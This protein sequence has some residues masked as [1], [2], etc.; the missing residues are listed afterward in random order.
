MQS[1]RGRKGL[2][3]TGLCLVLLC[4]LPSGCVALSV[5]IPTPESSSVPQGAHAGSAAAVEPASQHR[6]LTASYLPVQNATAISQPD[7]APFAGNDEL[8]VDLLVEQVLARNPTLA[9]MVA[10]WQAASARYPQVTLLEDPMVAGTIGPGTLSPDDPGV[11]FAYRVEVSQKL[12]F[13]GK[14]R[15][16]GENALAEA[17]AAGRDVE[18]VRLQLV[19]SARTAF[20]DYYLVDRALEVNNE[21][22]RLLREFR[23]NA[24]TRYQTGLVPEQDVLQADVEVGR[25]QDRRLELDQMRQVAVARIN[26]LMDLAPDSFLPSP[27]KQ[28]NVAEQLPD[29]RTLRATALARRPDLQALAALIAA[30]E[31]SLGLARKEFYPDFEPFFMYDR[32]M[33]NVSDNRD[34]ATMLGVRLNLPIY[35]AR[36]YGAVAEA[37]ARIAQRRAELAKVTDQ[38]NFQVQEAYARVQ[39]SEGSVRLYRDTILKAAEAN[40]KAAQSA[41]ITGK[42]P[43]LSLIEAERNLVMLRDRYYEAV[44]DYFRRHAA[45]ERAVGGL[46]TPSTPSN[47]PP[48]NPARRSPAIR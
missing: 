43:F 20:Y 21:S 45:L 28:L 44:A 35:K 46:L 22:L 27:P 42:T 32:F 4:G 5:A 9:Q 8:S 3:F 47:Q 1:T 12:P 19:E 34:L 39:R 17:S 29:V 14:L 16:R 48:P 11:E 25:E 26:T 37:E 23:S 31:A 6:I 24:Q 33:G 40:V 36:R 18:D 2:T 7:D 15:L 13:P 10:T 41:Y 30:E 38:V